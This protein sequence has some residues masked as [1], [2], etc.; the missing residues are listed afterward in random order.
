MIYRIFCIANTGEKL[1]HLQLCI[2]IESIRVYT[3]MPCMVVQCVLPH[4]IKMH[5]SIAFLNTTYQPLS[6]HVVKIIQSLFLTSFTNTILVKQL[7][8]FLKLV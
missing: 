8:L 7:T 6:M 2:T 1:S 4:N 3:D 5:P